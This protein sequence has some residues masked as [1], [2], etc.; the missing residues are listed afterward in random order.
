M[1]RPK[2]APGWEDRSAIRR[3]APL[4]ERYRTTS[5]ENIEN[6]LRSLTIVGFDPGET[7][8]WSVMSFP[9]ERLMDRR[10]PVEQIVTDWWHGQVDCGSQMG[11]RSAGV[12]PSDPG[13]SR[14]AE[15]HGAAVLENIVRTQFTRTIAVSVVF[16][17]FILR[18]Q[19]KKREALSPVRVTERVDQ[20]LWES[21]EVTVRRTQPS[22]AK[23][24]VTDE[25]LKMWGMYFD[26]HRERHAR[27]A[28]R[29][30]L[31]YLRDLRVK[32]HLIKVAFPI[33][34]EARHR[35][36]L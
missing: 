35:G 14:D 36:M 17:D 29:H 24:T 16:E 25:R 1:T 10:V 15:A 30:I 34:E 20:L 19:N 27:D 6:G 9:A 11:L 7:T 8:G 3:P 13:M 12:D 26:G 18:T 23:T 2:E 4:V 22:A 21:N 32:P 5:D 33:I 31:Y 28:D